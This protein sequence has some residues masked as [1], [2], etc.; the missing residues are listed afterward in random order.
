MET[1]WLC[2]RHFKVNPIFDNSFQQ[3]TNFHKPLEN[4]TFYELNHRQ[5]FYDMSDEQQNHLS[6]K[7]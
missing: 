1:F 4:S 2:S 6:G 5:N 7:F 3:Q